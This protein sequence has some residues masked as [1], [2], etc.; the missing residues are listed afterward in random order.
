[1]DEDMINKDIPIKKL[2]EAIGEENI[3]LLI[4]YIQ[5]SI[6]KGIE[7]NKKDSSS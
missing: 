4:N 3:K 2:K 7:K 1:M 6:K 5:K